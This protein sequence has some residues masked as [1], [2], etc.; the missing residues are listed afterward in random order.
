MGKIR[1][2]LDI[3]MEKTKN[4]SIDQEAKK[5]IRRKELADQARALVGRFVGGRAALKDMRS[6][7]DSSGEERPEV[8]GLVKQELLEHV[9]VEG[10]NLK[11]LEALEAFWG[12]SKD[13]TG[14]SIAAFR[15][16]LDGEMSRRLAE[17]KSDL[18]ARG[19]GGSAIIPNIT[20]SASW[21]N[22]LAQA[23]QVLADELGRLL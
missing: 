11:V 18:E 19:I 10:D 2:T 6:E 17:L 4:L 20:R 13:K 8:L 1:S 9:Q 14:S 16:K 21:Q 15:E 12:V 7:V 3:V 22:T 5:G 23:R